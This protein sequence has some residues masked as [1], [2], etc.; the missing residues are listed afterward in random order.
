MYVPGSLDESGG[1]R[2]GVDFRLTPL[3]C[4]KLGLW[5]T[6]AVTSCSLSLVRTGCDLINPD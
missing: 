6:V 1:V 2:D 3:S 5:Q 4:C